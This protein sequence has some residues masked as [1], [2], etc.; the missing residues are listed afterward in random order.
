MG[1][2]KLHFSPGVERRDKPEPESLGQYTD[3]K[4]KLLG[5]LPGREAQQCKFE[6]LLYPDIQILRRLVRRVDAAK[7]K[8]K[9]PQYKRTLCWLIPDLEAPFLLQPYPPS[10]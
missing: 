6:S 8:I 5:G 10:Y 7:I 2:G 3:G 4:E 1:P 9:K